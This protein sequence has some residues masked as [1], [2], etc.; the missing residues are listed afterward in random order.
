MDKKLSNIQKIHESSSIQPFDRDKYELVIKNI[1][2]FMREMGF[3]KLE[4][5]KYANVYLI[6]G[7]IYSIVP[8][9]KYVQSIHAV[10]IDCI[11][12][13]MGDNTNYCANPSSFL[14]C[15]NIREIIAK[16]IDKKPQIYREKEIENVRSMINGLNET[17]TVSSCEKLI[18]TKWELLVH[19]YDV[20]IWLI[21]LEYSEELKINN[22]N[23]TKYSIN[24]S[25]RKVEITENLVMEMVPK[26]GCPVIVKL[27]K[28]IQLLAEMSNFSC[29]VFT[30]DK[31][32]PTSL[33]VNKNLFIPNII[34]NDSGE[35]YDDTYNQFDNFDNQLDQQNL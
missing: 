2:N 19:H 3:Q 14:V 23:P 27:P 20:S 11:D 28:N 29:S 12:D 33:N 13:I 1:Q 15:Y 9:P 6:D 8:H 31:R 26:W 22:N 25:C 18:V 10:L 32:I 21:G 24:V 4:N 7:R 5:S 35:T 16:I 34:K 30:F 17:I